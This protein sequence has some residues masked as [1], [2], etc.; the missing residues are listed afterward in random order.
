MAYEKVTDWSRYPNFSKGEFDCRHTGRNEMKKEFMD[1][2]QALREDCGF[3]FLVSSGYRDATH[4]IEARKS[5]PGEHSHGLAADI[6]CNG[7]QAFKMVE[8]AYKHGFTRIG[9][10]QAGVGEFIH[11]GIAKDEDG[12]L[13]GTMW[14]Y[15]N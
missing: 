10:R 8:L 14:S 15:P 2:L 3:S 12:L 1:R 11:L 4:P 5:K 13:S 9:V 6:R 7:H